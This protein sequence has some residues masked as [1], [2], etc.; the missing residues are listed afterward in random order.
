MVLP[1]QPINRRTLGLIRASS[2]ILP[3]DD[4]VRS[5]YFE[6][7]AGARVFEPSTPL[8]ESV[9]RPA[10]IW[11]HGGG[12][13]MG[14]AAQDDR[15]CRKMADAAGITVVSADYRLA[16]EHP[17]PIPLADCY[18]ALQWAAAQPD[19]DP[20]RIVVAGASAGGGLAAA[21]AA[22]AHDRGEI[23]PVL[24]MLVYPMLDDRSD[25]VD[26]RH[27]VW[28]GDANRFGWSSYLG[29]TDPTIAV[30]ARRADLSGLAPAWI[31][32]GTLDLFYDED[33]AY[34]TRL[35]DSGVPCALEIIDGAFHGFDRFAPGSDVVESLFTSQL[36]AV[37]SATARPE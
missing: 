16:P 25:A 18:L 19:I 21:L 5:V 27:R 8:P 30:P 31:A 2:S 14:A 34:A 26:P 22:L 33:L 35:E 29:D 15:W 10:L 28:S 37:R 24:Q 9:R 13:V 6:G 23:S 36:A 17:Y 11:I 3:A 7:G 1:R 32:V 12:Y 4:S 20:A